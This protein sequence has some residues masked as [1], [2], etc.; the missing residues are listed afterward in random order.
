LFRELWSN[1]DARKSRVAAGLMKDA[2]SWL[3]RGVMDLGLGPE[4]F[5]I[6]PWTAGL[7]QTVE[8]AGSAARG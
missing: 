7:P 8:E 3:G 5:E 2:P 1:D 4:A 6:Q